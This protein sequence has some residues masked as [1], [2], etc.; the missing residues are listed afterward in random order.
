M[1]HG[2][3]ATITCPSDLDQGGSVQNEYRNQYHGDYYLDHTVPTKYK[4]TIDECSL[5]PHYLE[6]HEADEH[7]S[8]GYPFYIISKN[9][10]ADGEEMALTADPADQY[11][12]R[13]T[14]VHNVYLS[15]FAGKSSPNKLQQWV[16]NGKQSSIKSVGL[17]EGALFEGFNKNMIVYNW[18]GLHNQRFKYDL[19]TEKF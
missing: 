7:L 11:A 5:H 4:L 2:E 10:S 16:W 14:G 19:E 9:L 17:P 3:T 18:K 8:D 13:S 6:H 12:P 1:K 15:K